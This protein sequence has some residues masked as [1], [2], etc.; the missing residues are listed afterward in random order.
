MAPF[1]PL[2]EMVSKEISLSAWLPAR[3]ASSAVH[4]GNLVHRLTRRD[5][6][7]EP[8]EEPHY[9]GSVAH[10]RDP[11]ALDLGRVLDCLLGRC[12]VRAPHGALA[13]SARE[14][15]G[16]SIVIQPHA[17]LGFAQRLD[18]GLER[19]GRCNLHHA[20]ELR[21]RL[22]RQPLACEEQLRLAAGGH[23]RERQHDRIVRHVL[24]ANVEQPAHRVRST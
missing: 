21:L 3:C 17:P 12:R 24:A 7:I 19:G 16:R 6:V 4:G 10:M 22:A 20:V 15:E 13:E 14:P 5:R 2:P 9:R 1:G 23:D 18:A 11:R 8:G